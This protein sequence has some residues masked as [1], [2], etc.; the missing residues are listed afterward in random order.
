ML[1]SEGLTARLVRPRRRRATRSSSAIRVLAEIEHRRVFKKAG[2]GQSSGTAKEESK[3]ADREFKEKN[4]G[5]VGAYTVGSA[6]TISAD[7]R[8]VVDGETFLVGESSKDAI[9][10][11]ASGQMDDVVVDCL[12][13]EV[14]E[15][16]FTFSRFS[17]RAEEEIERMAA[18]PRGRISP[19]TLSTFRA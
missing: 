3:R 7:S 2:K 17:M 10:A 12:L 1:R 4:G 5:C 9:G 14:V 16:V 6:R 8:A 13:F 11:A 18:I 19:P 15:V